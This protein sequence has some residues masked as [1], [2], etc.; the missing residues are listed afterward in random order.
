MTAQFPLPPLPTPKGLPSGE[1]SW[2]VSSRASLASGVPLGRELHLLSSVRVP[3]ADLS[4]AFLAILAVPSERRM[5][6]LR[7][8]SRLDGSIP[9]AP[10]KPLDV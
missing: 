1:R 10:T 6:N 4:W 8:L 9:T 3:A 5:N 7:F 2:R